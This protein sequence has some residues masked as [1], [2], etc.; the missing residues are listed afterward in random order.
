MCVCFATLPTAELC[1]NKW[2]V[3]GSVGKGV[4]GRGHSLI[5]VLSQY[6]PKGRIYIVIAEI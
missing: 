2:L 6:M 1:G 4:R 5:E 3:D